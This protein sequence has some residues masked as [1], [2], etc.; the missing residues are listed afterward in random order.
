MSKFAIV[1]DSTSYIPT[2]VAQKHGITIAPQ[3]LIWDNQTYRDGIDIQPTDFYSRLKTAK[4]MPSTSQVSPATMQ[5]IFQGLVEKGTSVLGIFISSKLSGTLQSAIQAKDM[6]G[7]A[8]EKVTL[9]DSRSTAMGLGFQAII[10]ARAAEAGAS[11]EEAA[12]QASSAHERTGVFFAVDTL[13]FLHRG[14][15]IGGAQRFIGSALNLKPI[16]AVKEGK[17]EG[18]ERIRT[19]SKAHERV[20]ELVAEQVKGKSNVRIATLHANSADDAK[21]LLDRAAT[22]LSPVETLFT[23]VSP[24]VGTHAGPGTVGLA[25]IHD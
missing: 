12:A 5:E 11:I 9:V 19:K 24:V 7:S 25:Y 2:D 18:I 22:E 20:L 3:V 13:E 23:E 15:R 8:G 6:M 1:T 17:V 4:S 14:G 16:L 10:A 21:S